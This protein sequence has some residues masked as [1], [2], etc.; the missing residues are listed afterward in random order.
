MTTPIADQRLKK[1]LDRLSPEDGRYLCRLVAG[2]PLAGVFTK[3]V[4]AYILILVVFLLWPFDFVFYRTNGIRWIN[5]SQG[6]AFH[7]GGQALSTSSPKEFFS[8]MVKGAGVTLEVW[9]SS[10]N[11]SQ[12]GPARILSYS[13]NPNIRNFTLGQ[14]REQL[15]VRLRTTMTSQNGTNPHLIVEDA[16]VPGSVQHIVVTY[17]FAVQKVFINGELRMQSENLRGDF[18]NWDPT[19]RLVL[20]NEVTGNRPWRGELYYAAVFDGVISDGDIRTHYKLGW[21]STQKGKT[22]ASDFRADLPLMEYTLE[23]GQGNR[24]YDRGTGSKPVDLIIPRFIQLE[25]RA[26][27]DFSRGYF[28]SPSWFA[29]VAVNIMIFIPLGF[30]FHGMLRIR[31][32]LTLSVS[33][34]TL[35]VGALLTFVVETLQHYSMTRNSSLADVFTNITGTTLGIAMDRIY[36]LLLQI[37]VR[38]LEGHIEEEE[39]GNVE[40][41]SNRRSRYSKSEAN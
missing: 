39:S 24:I 13:K 14:S 29:D 27:L 11:T 15:V 36:Y 23:E 5:A 40:V 12:G 34:S 8:R 17:D 38:H 41:K 7:Q 25:T 2:D 1:I 3:L 18:S 22:G 16:L 33:L 30:L 21:P 32:G 4:P 31:S 26:F 28:K 35:L 19:C 9:L 37:R 20:G 10:E 6:I